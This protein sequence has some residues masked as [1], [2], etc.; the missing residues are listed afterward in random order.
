MPKSAICHHAL[1]LYVKTS[2]LLQ[3]YFGHFICMP[4]VLCTWHVTNFKGLFQFEPKL[5]CSWDAS[6][7]GKLV[8][9]CLQKAIWLRSYHNQ[10]TKELLQ[11]WMC[12][13][14]GKPLSYQKCWFISLLLDS[15]ITKR[16]SFSTTLNCMESNCK[17][18]L[19]K[20][21]M[22]HLHNRHATEMTKTWLK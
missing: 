21:I 8:R 7:F 19:M 10:G 22:F 6:L 17:H 12:R 3:P 1:L 16:R 4:V 14:N 20:L 11:E 18:H 2:G 15:N 5:K 9:I 13:I